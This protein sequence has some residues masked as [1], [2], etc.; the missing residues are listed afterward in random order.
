MRGSLDHS[1]AMASCRRNRMG[2]IYNFAAVGPPDVRL[3]IKIDVRPSRRRV[4]IV[5][6]P[7]P[8]HPAVERIL[9]EDSEPR[10]RRDATLHAL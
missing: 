3:S 5:S 1:G 6:D 8:L 9:E 10:A 2:E 7:A 4:E